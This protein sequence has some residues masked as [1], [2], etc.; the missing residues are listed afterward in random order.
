MCANVAIMCIRS[1]VGAGGKNLRDDVRTV[2]LLLN[3]H[4]AQ[5]VGPLVPDGVC[6][7]TTIAAIQQFQH[8]VI[9]GKDAAGIVTPDGTTLIALRSSMP[10]GFTEEK[11]QGILIHASAAN[12]THFFA[13]M[14]AAMQSAQI[15]TPLRQAHFL[16]QVGHESAELRYTEELASGAAYEGRKDLGNT[17]KG[18]GIRFKGRGLIQLTGRTNYIAFGK[19]VSQDLLAHPEV[20][21][22]DARLAVDVATWFWTQHD[23]NP[24]ADA[25]DIVTITH[26]INGGENGL[27]DRKEKLARAKWFLLDPHPDPA[28]PGLILAME[29]VA[30]E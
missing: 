14:L 10:P 29:A 3:M 1:S 15:N 23:L 9:G 11:L 18:D 26:R 16:A 4:H 21:S 25:D 24:L 28:L 19:S 12:C 2:Q 30:L 20:V 6:G 13:P 8:G 22:T 17:Q 27:A 7:P 5:I